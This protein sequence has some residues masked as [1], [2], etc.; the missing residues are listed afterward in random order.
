MSTKYSDNINNEVLLKVIGQLPDQFSTKDVSE[1]PDVIKAHGA[2]INH[3]QYHA[4]IGKYLKN[5]L[6]DHS[7][8]RVIEEIASGKSRGSVWRKLKTG[9]AKVKRFDS[10]RQH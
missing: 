10:A 2:L 5:D 8:G 4:F 6:R 7:G 1:H 9:S 3:R